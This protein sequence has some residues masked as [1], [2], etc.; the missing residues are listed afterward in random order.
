MVTEEWRAF[1]ALK[2]DYL[3]I[4]VNHQY[5]QFVNGAFTSNGVEY[6]WSLFKRGIIGVITIFIVLMARWISVAV[7]VFFLRFKNT[8][9]KN[10]IPI[11]TWGGLRGGISVALAL[12]LPNEMFKDEFVVI[13]YVVVVFSI[14]VQGLTIGKL[15]R[16]L[17]AK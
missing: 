2:G 5:G 15:A 10:A 3:H 11:L 13:T 7:P 14:L 1:N 12:S 16:E 6:F 9:E 17:S 8:F 4:T